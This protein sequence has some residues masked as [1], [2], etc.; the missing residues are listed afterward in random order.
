MAFA[1]P[2]CWLKPKDR[3][4][5][6]V[7]VIDVHETLL[8]IEGNDFNMRSET[9]ILDYRELELIC[10]SLRRFSEQYVGDCID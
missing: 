5:V 10:K 4:I 2:I 9:D 3:V 7:G 6:M 1:T 8:R